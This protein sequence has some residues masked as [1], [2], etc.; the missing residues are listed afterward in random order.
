MQ[1][2][3]WR[4]ANKAV[5]NAIHSNL[6]WY[7]FL[8]VFVASSLLVAMTGRYSMAFDEYYH[9]GT[10]KEYAKVWAPW[11]V[12]QP[13]GGAVLGSI[14]SDASY[15]YHYLMSFPYRALQLLTNSQQTQIVILRLIDVGLVAFG[16]ELFRRLLL[17]LGTPQG[18]AHSILAVVVLLPMTSFLAGQLTYDALLFAITPVCLWYAVRFMRGIVYENRFEL[19]TS[20]L[21]VASL[22]AACQVKYAFLPMA[23]VIVLSSLFLL[24]RRRG[25]YELALHCQIRS[26]FRSWR[27][28]AVSAVLALSLLGFV[29]RYGANIVQY[30][31][32][33]PECVK[34]LTVERCRS[35]APVGRDMSYH[36]KGYYKNVTIKDKLLYPY[37]WSKQMVW[38]SFFVVGP[39]HT[40]YALGQPLQPAY[41]TGAVLVVALLV[42][43][44]VGWRRLWRSGIEAC[45]LTAV[46]LAYVGMLFARNYAGY[47][48][49]GFPVAVHGRY[50]L[51][52]LP[53]MG[54][55]VW[56]VVQRTKWSRR[57]YL[58]LVGGVMLLLLMAGGGVLPYVV[59]STSEW[60]WQGSEALVRA[61]A[62]VA[63][64]FFR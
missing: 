33:V 45:V 10:I 12:Q 31:S 15:L 3:S 29:A 22:A 48:H 27:G 2:L 5:R 63:G 25:R 18:V 52:L 64:L 21:L 42:V 17:R 41:A 24:L 28:V 39:E 16:L 13:D 6:F 14:E 26:L 51:H 30:H 57:Q 35:Y 62:D 54:W 43:L 44:V 9:F 23:A 61:I 20:L 11:S 19:R 59:R 1:K 38:E 60:W 58:P 49:T 46:C 40:G 8:G 37:R 56:R 47:L 34:V 36:E 50:V 53:V 4:L 7:G 32:P 55:L